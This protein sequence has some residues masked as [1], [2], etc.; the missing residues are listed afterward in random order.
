MKNSSLLIVA[1]TFPVS[2]NDPVPT[3]VRDQ[4]IALKKH[5]PGLKINI[6]AP[7]DARSNT[8]SFN[9]WEHYDEYRF[10]Y[11]WPFCIEKLAGRGIMPAL[12]AN[13]FNYL[14][15]P[16]LFI[17]ELIALTKL[18]RKLRPLFIYAHWFTPQAVT[19]CWVGVLTKTPFI[20]TTHAA[21]VAVWHKI[22]I[23]GRCL[24][25]SCTQRARAFTAVSRRSMEK[26]ERFF[27]P[28]E[29]SILKEKSA[30][31]PMGTDVPVLLGPAK[32]WTSEAK[33]ILFIGRLVEKKGVHYLLSAFAE[34]QKFSEGISLTIL[35][36]GPLLEQLKQQAVS[37][38]VSSNVYFPGYIRGAGKHKYLE[39]ADLFVVP[40]IIT[41]SGDAEGLPV[42]LM[43][44]LAY[45]KIC[46]ATNESGAD[47]II[48][49][50]KSGFLVR[51]KDI[52][53]LTEV[54]KYALSL[55]ANQ[56]R[57]MQKHARETAEQFDWKQIAKM[58]YEF[59]ERQFFN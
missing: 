41:A 46:I 54:L 37:L 53:Q 32:E 28:I 59:F 42:S 34:L 18:V 21:D 45:G 51:G 33:N 20:F 48:A 4:A 30:L 27:L 29:W 31:I 14:L 40:S 22:P 43:E 52:N 7:H 36:D 19:A 44:G 16:F 57:D 38:D 17:G 56:V 11:A 9:A 50:K 6:L 12:K 26:L 1:S 5:Y 55:D 35:G 39:E 58:H 47:D 8:K 24:V 25:R 13:P 10:H 49:D 23:I 2:E 15:I 3:F